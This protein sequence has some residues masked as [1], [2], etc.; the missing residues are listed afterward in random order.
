MTA[1]L[2]RNETVWTIREAARRLNAG[3]ATYCDLPTEYSC[4]ALWGMV[5]SHALT[6][7]YGKLFAPSAALVYNYGNSCHFG[8]YWLDDKYTRQSGPM[9]AKETAEF[10]LTA[11]CLYA[12]MVE[13]GDVEGL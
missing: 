5:V 1:A 8:A 9:S 3:T 10:R 6:D 4:Q 11:M 2:S 12:A 7:Q 13:A